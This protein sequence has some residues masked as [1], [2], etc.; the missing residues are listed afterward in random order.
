MMESIRRNRSTA[1]EL[2]L[3][4]EMLH[5]NQFVLEVHVMNSRSILFSFILV[6][7]LLVAACSPQSADVTTE[8]SEMAED[9]KMESEDDAM[10]EEDEE[11]AEAEDDTMMEDDDE[12]SE[13]EDDAM[14][15]DD[16]EMAESEDDAM[17]EDDM[18]ATTFTLR[19]ENVSAE[20]GLTIL[21]PGAF[22]LN[23]HPVSFF[24][25]GE[26]D[27]GEGLE[28][29]A[30]DG[31][32]SGLVESINA[33]MGED[34]MGFAIGAFNTPVG[35]D[36]PGPI[37]PG[38]AYEFSIEAHSGQY[39][40]FSTMFVQSNDW[41]FA[42]GSEGIALFDADGNPISGDI[43]D[44]IFLW[45]AGTEADQTPGEGPDQ[46]PRQAG[47]NT[48]EDENGT[49]ELVEEFSDYQILVT[50]TPHQ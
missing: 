48:G 50:I 40:T 23:D 43:S 26:A 49:V 9:E 1:C 21:A 31:D 42:P 33:M 39:L 19:I 10:M 2:I 11:M 15:E 8:Q 47:S 27:R 4:I 5:S 35:A 37:G 12:M 14:M 28:A 41:F 36:A 17:M 13:S 29:L 44:Q 24:T 34:M 20:D 18:A 7:A 6:L 25:P 38:G 32:P 3:L 22:E 45:D 16:D 46:A 30:E